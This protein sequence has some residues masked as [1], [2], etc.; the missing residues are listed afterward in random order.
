MVVSLPRGEAASILVEQGSTPLG[1]V[2]GGMVVK[3]AS[4]V[5]SASGVSVGAS[6]GEAVSVGGSEVFVGM[7]A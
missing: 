5:G 1:A 2:V 3:V 6:V 4:R 7:A